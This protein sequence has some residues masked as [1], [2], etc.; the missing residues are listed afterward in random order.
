MA[1]KARH[2]IIR[3]AVFFL[4][5]YALSSCTTT[6]NGQKKFLFAFNRVSIKNY[7][8]GKP[9][10][11]N[12]N[13]KVTGTLPSDEKKRLTNDLA[14][15]WDDSMHAQRLQ[16][17]GVFFTIKN[18]PVFDTANLTRTKIFMT[19]YLNS[20]G[21]Y[22]PVFNGN[23]SS[24]FIDTVIKHDKP[25]YRTTVTVTVS[26]GKQTIIDS[27]AYSLD[28][29]ILNRISENNVKASVIKPGKTPF[30][31]QV[32]ASELDRLVNLYRQRGYFLITRDNLIA[33]IDTSLISPE[34]MTLDPFEQARLIAEAAQKA[35][36]NPTCDVV[37]QKRPATDST[38]RSDSIYF[39]R[40]YI[41]NIYYFPETRLNDIPDSLLRDTASFR[42]YRENTFTMYY[43]RKLF[44][45]GVLRQ[46]TFQGYGH[47]Y[48]ED[49]FFKTLNNLNQIG[50]WDR[51]DYR[52]SIRKDSVDFYYFLT[53]AK[54]QTVSLN[55]EAS[56]STGDFLSTSNLLGL[57]FNIGYL[58]RNIL[59]SA[60]QSNTI[61]SNGVEFGFNQSG[62][63]L[64]T[65]QSSLTQSF[66]IPHLILLDKIL[67]TYRLDATRTNLLL[68][69]SYY[70]RKDFYRLRSFTGNTGWQWKQ[71]NLVWQFKFP[72]VEIYSLDTLHG[73]DSAFKTNPF[74][75]TSFNTGAVVG[76]QGNLVFTYPGRSNNIS[77]YARFAGE[78]SYL[79]GK[80]FQDRVYRFIKF[81][82]EYRK[83]INLP[84][85]AWAFRG[86]AG[87]GYNFGHSP[88]FG[89][90]L[91]FFKQF[92]AGGPNSMR[93]WGLRL[94]GL[95]SSVV[96]DTAALFRDRYGDMQLETNAEFRF[97]VAQFSSV[98]I[99]SALFVDMGNIWNI[100][101]NDSVP[102]SEFSLKRLGQD[103]AIGIGTGLRFDFSYFLI[104]VDF[105]IKLKDPARY[106]VNNGWLNLSDFTWK[107]YIYSKK[108][109]DT[110]VYI[111]A[112]RNNYAIQ[113]GIGLPF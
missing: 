78:L 57:A 87:V 90:T 65:L 21:Y 79:P 34:L 8:E 6:R 22:T 100:H 42:A 9:F 20:Q 30:S 5:T 62:S 46:H 63:F 41:G 92:V 88:H 3:L 13:I 48:N 70:D 51:I 53:P 44:K 71:K 28:D 89:N 47:L 82:A 91:P 72:N 73:L 55:L 66:S 1:F 38:T 49:N 103:W 110:G 113:L 4:S 93:A 107:N 32:I 101:K 97:N 12:N 112:T 111:P 68:N 106:T 7:P 25:Q 81:E 95:G 11:Y 86:F 59:R 94:L 85:S 43:Q 31:K 80:S 35:K 15:Y 14:G 84:K 40:F 105:G 102:N 104:R 83:L 98:K 37:I 39:T 17:F 29:S 108:D 2:V 56:H 64:Q 26:P 99:G 96:S 50:A 45:F 74:L 109:H 18:P 61:L 19:G 58:N 69:A 52:T 16:K 33:E 75:R 76:G 77:N 27:L 24:F 10:V 60:I 54:K 36:T 67:N 23:D